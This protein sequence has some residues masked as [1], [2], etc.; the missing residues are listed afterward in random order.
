MQTFEIIRED[1]VVVIYGQLFPSN[2]FAVA[3]NKW[4][5]PRV[6]LTVWCMN[7]ED[8]KIENLVCI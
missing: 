1:T 7:K 5:S 2:Y 4:E 6:L 8:L 3:G